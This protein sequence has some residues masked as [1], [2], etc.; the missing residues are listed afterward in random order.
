MVIE[1]LFVRHEGWIFPEV[2]VDALVIVKKL[3]HSVGIFSVEIRYV[4]TG[5][6]RL[7]R[8][9]ALSWRLLSPRVRWNETQCESGTAYKAR[10]I[11]T[12]DERSHKGVTSV[13]VQPC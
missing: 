6:S 10:T 9:R 8:D 1:I 3:V 4:L 2:L 11:E 13:L 12:F 7:T 5:D